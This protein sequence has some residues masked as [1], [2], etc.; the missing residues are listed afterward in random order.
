[1][2][3]FYRFQQKEKRRSGESCHLRHCCIPLV[4]PLHGVKAGHVPGCRVMDAQEVLS[5]ADQKLIG[6]PLHAELM[7]L[8]EK[9]KEDKRRI[10][11]LKASRKFRPV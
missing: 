9:F 10:A 4:L 6:S 3:N 7:D 8:R 2:T 5:R 11:E 1:M